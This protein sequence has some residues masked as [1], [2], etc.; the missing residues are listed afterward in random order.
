MSIFFKNF[1]PYSKLWTAN[2]PIAWRKQTQPYNNT[3]YKRYNNLSL[4]FFKFQSLEGTNSFLWTREDCCE[5][6]LVSILN[7]CLDVLY[8]RFKP[9]VSPPLSSYLC[10]KFVLGVCVQEVFQ[11]AFSLFLPKK[12]VKFE[13]VP[14]SSTDRL[15]AFRARVGLF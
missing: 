7:S 2:W 11:Q 9:N 14:V 15:V 12:L 6:L 4:F 3:N 8:W 13:G 10:K 1:G 5:L